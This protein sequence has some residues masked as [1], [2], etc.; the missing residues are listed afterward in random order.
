MAAPGNIEFLTTSARAASTLVSGQD[1]L[2][3]YQFGARR[4]HHLFCS[5]CGVRAFGRGTNGKGERVVMINARCVDDVDLGALRTR[6]FDGKSL[7]PLLNGELAE[8]ATHAATVSRE[9]AAALEKLAIDHLVMT[10]IHFHDVVF[11]Y[12]AKV[13]KP[14]AIAHAEYWE[15]RLTAAQRRFVRALE[16]IARFVQEQ[17][18]PMRPIS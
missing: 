8:S 17:P 11:C 9:V 3:D 12:D 1:A 10:W 13:S 6:Q 15:R 4:V 14:M 7:L 2:T 16:A 5:T 18:S